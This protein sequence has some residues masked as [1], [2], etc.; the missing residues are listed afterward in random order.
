M[1]IKVKHEG[2]V[3]SR[4]TAAG[5][6]GQGKRAAEDGKTFA[7]IAAGEAQAANRQ[8][9]GA[10]ASPVS[11]GHASAP[12]THASTGAAPGITHAPSGGVRGSTLSPRGSGGVSGSRVRTGSGASSDF[13][14]KVTGTNFQMRPDDES[15]W[16]GRLGRWEREWLPGE[17]EAEALR[18]TGRVK[19]NLE[20]E[21]LEEK[22]RQAKDSAEQAALLGRESETHKA[23]LNGPPKVEPKKPPIQTT[24]PSD[25]NAK[26]D[27]PNAQP[28][29]SNAQPTTPPAASQD[30]P[31]RKPSGKVT[32]TPVQPELYNTISKIDPQL[33]DIRQQFEQGGIQEP[34]DN[35]MS[36]ALATL[37]NNGMSNGVTP[38]D[39]ARGGGTVGEV[40]D[41]IM[42]Q[43]GG[44]APAASTMPPQDELASVYAN[45]G[46]IYDRQGVSGVKPLSWLRSPGTDVSAG[47]SSV[48][49]NAYADGMEGIINA[50]T[51][52][53]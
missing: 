39:L 20:L 49:E 3:T 53:V 34:F 4:I 44:A 43:S 15:V 19:N 10:H 46:S 50:L 24:M 32:I 5:A 8:L 16:N 7:Q 37:S 22:H 28:G 2:N 41:S 27:D 21:I 25:P 11:P 29:D 40:F 35:A 47:G 30:V 42:A 31:P 6:G 36:V 17:K 1:A 26:P 18:R 12:L 33:V 51:R 13:D 38:S 23:K 52:R 9:Q 45:G 14:L 48:E